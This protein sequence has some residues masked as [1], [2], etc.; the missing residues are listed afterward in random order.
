MNLNQIAPEVSLE[1]AEK[2]QCAEDQLFVSTQFSEGKSGDQVYLMT[3]SSPPDSTQA[4]EYILKIRKHSSCKDFDKEIE[5]THAAKN[6]CNSDKIRIP[7]L[8]HFSVVSGYYVYDVAGTGAKETSPLYKHAPEKK[9]SRLEEVIDSSLFAWTDVLSTGKAKLSQIFRRWLGETRLSPNSRL[10]DRLRTY[11]H[12]ELT[13]AFQMSGQIFPNPYYYF[14]CVVSE[15]T[16]PILNNALQGPQHGDFN[17]NNILIQPEGRGHLYYLI[18]FSHYQSQSFLLF[19]QAYLLLDILLDIDGLLLTEWIEHLQTFFA[20]LSNTEMHIGAS[21]SFERYTS[22]FIEGWR[23]FFSRYPHNGREVIIQMLCACAAA[24][25][26]FMHKS[27]ASESKQIFSLIFSSLAIKRL[28]ELDVYT[29]PSEKGEY[30]KLNDGTTDKIAELWNVT[31]GFSGTSRYILLS[32]C[33]P[34]HIHL[35]SFCALEPVPWT[36]IIEINHL[37]ENDLRNN[38]L[39]RFR[40]Q[41]G[42]H[43]VLLSKTQEFSKS[44][45][46]NMWC[47]IVIDREVNNQSLFY[48]RY[49][50]NHLLAYMKSIL[51][52]QEKYPLCILIDSRNLD[53]D[54][55]D[56]ILYDLLAA[57]G[58]NTIIDIIY[59][60]D[61]AIPFDE[62]DYIK[63]HWIPSSLG[64]L[65]RSIQMSFKRLDNDYDIQIPT[66]NGFTS[67]DRGIVTDIE[68]DMQIIHRK[69]TSC[70]DDDQGEAF[71]HGGEASWHDIA[72]HRDVIRSDYETIWHD[73]IGH[74][75]EHLHSSISAFVWLYHRPGSGGSTMAKR[76]MWDFCSKYPT[77]YLKKISD[78]TAE[79]LKTF[80]GLSIN[81]PLLIVTEINNSQIST[82]TLASLRT[83]LIKKGIRA[84]FIYI[85]RK[86]ERVEGEEQFNFYLPD[87]PQMYLSAASEDACNMYRKFSSFLDQELDAD[88]LADLINLTYSEEQYSDELRQPFFYGLFTFGKD[89]RKIEEYVHRNLLVT[90]E[91]EKLMLEILSFHTAY[92]ETVNLN[93]QEIAYILFP[94]QTLDRHVFEQTRDILAKN[95]FVVHRGNGYRISHPLIAEKLLRELLGDTDYNYKLVFLAKQVIDTL[96]QFYQFD[97]TRLDSILHELFI[98]R[99]PL[100][101]TQRRFFSVFITE[102]DNDGQRIEIM[103]YLNLKF[104]QNPHYSNHLARLY[105]RPQDDYQRPD[106]SNAKK[107][108]REAIKR[109]ECLSEDSSSIHHHLMGKVCAR[110][111]ISQFRGALA[112]NHISYAIKAMNSAYQEAFREFNICSYGKNSTY[113]LVGKLELINQIFSEIK[114]KLQTTIPRLIA[115]EQSIDRKLIE[116]IS[117]AGTIIQQYMI[118]HDELDPAFQNARMNFY[119]H[120]GKITN[121]ESMINVNPQNLQLRVQSRRSI[122]TILEATA[123]ESNTALSYNQIEPK[124]LLKIKTLMEETIYKD[125]SGSNSDRFR[126]LEAYRRLDEFQ[127]SKAYQFVMEWPDSSEKLD[128]VYYRYILSF[129]YYAKYQGCSYQTVKQHLNQC[130]QL[131]MRAYGKYMNRTRDLLGYL[132]GDR[133]DRATLIPWQFYEFGIDQDEREQKNKEH[134]KTECSYVDGSVNSI[135]D[136]MVSF[137]FSMEKTGNAVFYAQTPRIDEV[138][139]LLDGQQVKFHLG[140]SYSGFRAWDIT[141]V[142]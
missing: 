110:D 116:M 129:L 82:I 15:E 128:I 136:G 84:L 60:S 87:T 137:R 10:V 77:V 2:F 9:I 101:E 90:S 139:S 119:K 141:K 62:D 61:Y 46:K 125:T 109:A 43:H 91:Q 134:R 130:Q 80:Y 56:L 76:I 50:R 65:S 25:L 41:R 127:L 6:A 115:K 142:E 121:I 93:T 88:R 98:Y 85:S 20:A 28:M 71:Y 73:R 38:A 122:V 30:P 107:Y 36:A 117:E 32:S 78:R 108:A 66:P 53:S 63:S 96:G 8:C 21:C 4:G 106:I 67:L 123:R 42:Y 29:P 132:D 13:E 54:I 11:I 99:E 48:S 3:V 75:L 100:N 31:D 47:S 135:R 138:S 12:D 94:G 102:L 70:M 118:D 113:G 97:S 26:N 69:L 112:C 140:F 55:R 40:K 45:D 103:E 111:C 68:N 37:L 39:Q 19:D 124:N 58:E 131:A 24:G 59:L 16:D 133:N 120:M 79:R 126:W 44:A 72:Y 27:M 57:A 34:E 51:E 1:I 49:I 105:L 35:D 83:E 7:D 52:Q 95:C 104:K 81:M 17:Q 86:N 64:Q 92:S 74:R 33:L 18:D 22:A 23:R 89:Y 14:T 114:D 5:N